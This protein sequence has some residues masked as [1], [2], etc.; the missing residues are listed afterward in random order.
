VSN[1]VDISQQRVGF[2]KAIGD[3]VIISDTG[4]GQGD[5]GIGKNIVL[6][7]KCISSAPWHFAVSLLPFEFS[8]T[9]R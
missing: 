6:L 4:E 5:I 8:H 1:F 3:E 7:A 9:L 2:E